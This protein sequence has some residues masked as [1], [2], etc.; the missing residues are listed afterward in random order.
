MSQIDQIIAILGPPQSQGEKNRL[1][2][3]AKKTKKTLEEIYVERVPGIVENLDSR[4]GSGPSNLDRLF[5]E[6]LGKFSNSGRTT[7]RSFSHGSREIQP[8]AETRHSPESR[9]RRGIRN[10]RLIVKTRHFLP[11]RPDPG[12]ASMADA[13]GSQPLR[14]HKTQFRNPCGL[15]DDLPASHLPTALSKDQPEFIGPHWFSAEFS[16]KVGVFFL[17]MTRKPGLEF[18]AQ[19]VIINFQVILR[20]IHDVP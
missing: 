9:G 6:I 15:S 18:R 13:C 7:Y 3:L 8:G 12:S 1:D 16:M 2:G 14:S 5:S 4:D 11:T 17:K 10:L 20:G 19:R